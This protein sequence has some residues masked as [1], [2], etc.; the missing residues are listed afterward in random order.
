MKKR[1][2][3]IVVYEQKKYG[4]HDALEKSNF[5]LIRNIK[6]NKTSLEKSKIGL[7]LIK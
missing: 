7:C 5:E 2:N 6:Q 3:A 1:K 4:M